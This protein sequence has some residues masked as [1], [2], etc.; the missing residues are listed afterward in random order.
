MFCTLARL[1]W[2]IPWPADTQPFLDMHI[3][4]QGK[5]VTV[6]FPQHQVYAIGIKHGIG[7]TGGG[8]HNSRMS[9]KPGKKAWF[10]QWVGDDLP[11]YDAVVKEVPPI[12]PLPHNHSNIPKVHATPNRKII[13]TNS[14]PQLPGRGAKV[15]GV[16]R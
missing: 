15:K 9:Y 7:K 6:D 14:R 2:R 4:R 3:H 10:G 11:F 1:P 5:V 8:G 16:R 13:T 12:G